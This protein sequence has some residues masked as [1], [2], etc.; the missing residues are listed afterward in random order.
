MVTG[1]L[2]AAFGAV[3]LALH[4]HAKY[5]PSLRSWATPLLASAILIGWSGSAIFAWVACRLI[6][7]AI[8]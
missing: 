4:E 1:L 8:S 6:V 2:M 7:E 5:R 3:L